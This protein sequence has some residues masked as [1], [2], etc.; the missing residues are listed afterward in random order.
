MDEF[1]WAVESFEPFTFNTIKDCQ[2]V[3]VGFTKDGLCASSDIDHHI[4]PY[5]DVKS[6][7]TLDL[8]CWIDD[9]ITN[10]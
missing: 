10:V 6:F 9:A 4:L 8:L 7:S 2:G 1:L 5:E 3:I